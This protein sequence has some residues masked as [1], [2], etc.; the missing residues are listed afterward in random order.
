MIQMINNKISKNKMNNNNKYRDLI[1]QN[2]K[3]FH[4][5]LFLKMIYQINKVYF[6]LL[7]VELEVV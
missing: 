4:Q 1:F 3:K 5:N 2:N 7:F 6:I